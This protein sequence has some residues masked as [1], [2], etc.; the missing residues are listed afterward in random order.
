MDVLQ[1]EDGSKVVTQERDDVVHVGVDGS[2]LQTFTMPSDPCALSYSTAHNAV[3][4]K[5]LSDG[6][7]SLLRDAWRHSVR[8]AW[9]HATCAVQKD[10][11]PYAPSLPV[12][13][14]ILL[15]LQHGNLGFFTTA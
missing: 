2:T 5:T 10:T 14:S 4:V 7:V 9:L 6:T 11:L 12:P 8:A 15:Q 1:C 13:H 3:A